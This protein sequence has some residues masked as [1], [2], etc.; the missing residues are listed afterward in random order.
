MVEPNN[1]QKKVKPFQ[2]YGVMSLAFI[3]VRDRTP[4]IVFI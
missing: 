2:Y 1:V 3:T 4:M